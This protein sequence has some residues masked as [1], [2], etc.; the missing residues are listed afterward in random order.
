[1]KMSDKY[2]VFL[3]DSIVTPV[4]IRIIELRHKKA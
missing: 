1:M 4:F 2:G 3:L